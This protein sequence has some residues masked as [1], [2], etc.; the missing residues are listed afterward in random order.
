MVRFFTFFAVLGVVLL[1]YLSGCSSTT[2]IVT[3]G[4]GSTTTNGF[5]LAVID[6]EGEPVHNAAVRLRPDDYLP[7]MSF[8]TDSSD[9]I[10]LIDTV[11][12]ESGVIA[13]ARITP[14]NYSIEIV[15]QELG[16]GILIHD[17]IKPDTMR[18]LGVATVLPLGNLS[19]AVD[20]DKL[21]GTGMFIIEIY[22]LERSAEVDP[23]TGVFAIDGL[24]PSDYRLRL[25]STDASV[26]PVEDFATVTVNSDDTVYVNRFAQW[27]HSARIS[28]NPAAAGLGSGDTLYRFP[29]AVRL[30]AEKFDFSTAKKKGEDF[31]IMKENGD[32]VAFE[33]EWWDSTN[34]TASL[35]VLCDTLAGDATLSYIMHWGN[36]NASTVS[37][38]S[39]VFDTTFGYRGVWHFNE[40]GGKPQRDATVN[41]NDGVPA[42]MDGANDVTGLIGRAQEFEGDSQWITIENRDSASMRFSVSVWI[43]ADGVPTAVQGILS[44]ADRYGELTLNSES[45]WVYASP[46]GGGAGQLAGLASVGEW[47]NLCVVGTESMRY[48]YVNGMVV[49]SMNSIPE[50]S[51]TF[52]DEYPIYIGSLDASSGWLL[53]T[54]DEV[55]VHHRAV[56]DK[57]IRACYETQ[58]EMQ[59]VVSIERIQ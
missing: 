32:D 24:P 48:L 21:D 37:Q 35:W 54:V 50:V 40:S 13:C 27:N 23:K 20:P 59:T 25:S 34:G 2:D 8:N 18:N 43:F 11:T 19:G 14:G 55:R 26:A 6:A 52:K 28:V 42:G 15:D 36:R 30:H 56:S 5:T 49:D 39:A 16:S 46:A 45:Q 58:R 22:G 4:S 7:G 38:A 31:R 51:D 1:S 17:E 33:T 9:G 29:L 57:W 44:H 41:G 53:G 3:G 47:C 10:S 12:D